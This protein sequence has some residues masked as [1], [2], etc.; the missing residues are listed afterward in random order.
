MMWMER[1]KIKSDRKEKFLP[2]VI[3]FDEFSVG[4]ET[5]EKVQ[6][7]LVKHY[8]L[9]VAQARHFDPEGCINDI[10]VNKLKG[11]WYFHSFVEREDLIRNAHPHEAEQRRKKWDLMNKFERERK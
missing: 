2:K 10:R 1:E 7:F 9:R 8:K 11:K 3:V 5:L 4:C 6:F